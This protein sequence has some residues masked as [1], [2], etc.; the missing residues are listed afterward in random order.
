L[1]TFSS[2]DDN[3]ISEAS[4]LPSSRDGHTRRASFRPPR[5]WSDSIK[6]SSPELELSNKISSKAIGIG[7]AAAVFVQ[8]ISIVIL[9]L[10]AK[11][12]PALSKTTLPMRVVLF[13]VGLWWAVFTIPTFLWL[14][15]RPGPPLPPLSSRFKRLPS[16]LMYVGF[17]WHSL[18]KTGTM[19]VQLR[20]V[21]VFLIAW[22]ILSDAIATISGTAILFAR[23][24]LQMETA[25][26]A[27]LSVVATA[28]GFLGAVAWPKIATRY[29]LTSNQVI[30]ACIAI[31]EIIPLYGLLGFLPFIQAW[32]VGGLQKQWES[33]CLRSQPLLDQP[34]A[35]LFLASVFPLGCV[36][37]LIMGL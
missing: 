28:S 18:W 23:T 37:G 21:V 20:Q 14:R 22:F 27:V 25:A 29:R 8:L 15:T 31:F 16:W 30:I 35:N 10:F 2:G 34:H 32:G 19:A 24:E 6:A 33:T 3:A 26:I 12:S 1:E 36:L 5:K 9:V 13:I 11:V 4:S 7:Y 17:A